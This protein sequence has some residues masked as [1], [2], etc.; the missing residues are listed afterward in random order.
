MTVPLQMFIFFYG[1]AHGLPT[2]LILISISRYLG[3]KAF[4]AICG[5]AVMSMSPAAFISPVHTGWIFDSTGSYSA[6]LFVFT[7]ISLVVIILLSFLKT[8]LKK[9]IE[10][11]RPL[12]S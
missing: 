2:P 9:Q 6:A 11:K 8:P 7:S 4:C 12:K 1:L 10:R 5:M 3:R